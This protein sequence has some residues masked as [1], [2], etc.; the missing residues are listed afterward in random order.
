[1]LYDSLESFAR[2]VADYFQCGLTRNECCVWSVSPSRL[3]GAR[4]ALR[5]RL[6]NFEAR[7][8]LGQI[9]I[10]SDGAWRPDEN[11]SMDAFLEFSH[12]QSQSISRMG[13][14]GMRIAIDA[15]QD[16]SKP[17]TAFPA[18]DKALQRIASD[19][20]MTLLC[21]YPVDATE[22]ASLLHIAHRHGHALLA[23][24]VRYEHIGLIEPR[25]CAR[26]S[27]SES[28]ELGHASSKLT[29]REKAVLNRITRGESSKSIAR[30][31]GIS[32][33]TVEFHR[34]KLLIKLRARNTADLVCKA[35]NASLTEEIP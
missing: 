32:P 6:V 22:A 7:E 26:E 13:Y 11:R 35:I 10:V 8:R 2:A 15:F 4:D 19:Q 25:E 18:C 30:I 14:S 5:S 24:K 27:E 28:G 12:G 34:A 20:N 1:M 23:R 33:R 31:L 9:R 3:E 21:A 29:G 16:S 17:S